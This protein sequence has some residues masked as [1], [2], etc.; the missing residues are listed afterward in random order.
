MHAHMHVCTHSFS[1]LLSLCL[2]L[3]PPLFPLSF[4]FSL[5]TNNN[6]NLK[7]GKTKSE[8]IL[9]HNKGLCGLPPPLFLVMGNFFEINVTE[10]MLQLMLF[11]V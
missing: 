8:F 4:E 3:S 1:S 9:I 5:N 2:P 11:S 6:K 10:I 7:T